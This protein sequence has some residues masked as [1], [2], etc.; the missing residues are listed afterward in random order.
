VKAAGGIIKEAAHGRYRLAAA[1]G[2]QRTTGTHQPLAGGIAS[3][4][5]ALPPDRSGLSCS[6]PACLPPHLLL[7]A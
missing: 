4:S 3:T 7:L 6:L 5:G 1:A 2:Q